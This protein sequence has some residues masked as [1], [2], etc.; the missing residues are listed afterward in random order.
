MDTPAV[1]KAAKKRCLCE[2]C[3]TAHILAAASDSATLNLSNA[4]VMDLPTT[5]STDTDNFGH[6]I[7][8]ATL[9][10]HYAHFITATSITLRQFE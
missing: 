9:K 5:T 10:G 2:K 3:A 8:A 1:R 7:S 4:P 6:L